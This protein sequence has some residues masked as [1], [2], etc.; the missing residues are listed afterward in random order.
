MAAVTIGRTVHYKLPPRWEGD[1]EERL[2]PAT[3]VNVFPASGGPPM[4]NLT[5]TLDALNDL[6]DG[7]AA[8]EGLGQ[9]V[10]EAF[11]AVGSAHEG[12]DAGEW[13]W[14]ARS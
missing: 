3:V 9:V 6:R 5:V 14:P 4:A 12:E 7:R 10:A 2:R 13:R 8:L 11:L 1:T